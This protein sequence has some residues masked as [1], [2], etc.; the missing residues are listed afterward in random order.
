MDV[1]EENQLLWVV[2]SSPN[3]RL[4]KYMFFKNNLGPDGFAKAISDQKF[5]SLLGLCPCCAASSECIPSSC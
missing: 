4:H 2:L 3:G 5:S 1:E